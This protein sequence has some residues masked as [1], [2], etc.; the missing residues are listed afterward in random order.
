MIDA[1]ADLGH[2][3]DGRIVRNDASFPVVDPS[4]GQVV[5]H[6]PEATDALLDEAMAAAQRTQP[7]WYALGE[8]DRQ[9]VIAEMGETLTAHLDDIVAISAREKGAISAA[10]EAYAA[11]PSSPIWPPPPC[12]STCSKTPRSAR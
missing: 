11:P 8:A 1:P 4:S 6:C 5:A 7:Q 12:R 9:A 2:L 10:L 3:V